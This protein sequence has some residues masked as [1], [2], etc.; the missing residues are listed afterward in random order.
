MLSPH[1]SIS[2]VKSLNH[3][4]SSRMLPFGQLIGLLLKSIFSQF[5]WCIILCGEK[6]KSQNH[7]F[8][9]PAVRDKLGTLWNSVT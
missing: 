8:L 5:S 7:V 1:V 2:D 3:G 6:E 9:P 4:L